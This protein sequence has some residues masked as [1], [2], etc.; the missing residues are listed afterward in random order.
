M[1]GE[2]NEHSPL[3]QHG[4]IPSYSS[5]DSSGLPSNAEAQD[6]EA[7]NGTSQRFLNW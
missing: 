4:T 2:E 3:L 1:E 5:T 6:A 7:G